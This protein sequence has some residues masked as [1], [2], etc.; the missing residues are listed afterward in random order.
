MSSFRHFSLLKIVFFYK[1]LIVLK[2]LG[3]KM[4]RAISNY[5]TYPYKELTQGGCIGITDSNLDTVKSAIDQCI[6]TGCCLR[7]FTHG[8]Y[9]NN[10]NNLYTDKAIYTEMLDYIKEKVDAVELQVMTYRDF[11]EACS[12]E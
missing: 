10:S 5:Y 1:V 11:Y 3:F 9:E 6:Q 12:M 7:I 2:D 4:V 8:V